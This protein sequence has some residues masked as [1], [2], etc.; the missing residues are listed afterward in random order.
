MNER[1]SELEKINYSEIK[2]LLNAIDHE[3]INTIL[4]NSPSW[5]DIQFWTL[6]VPSAEIYVVNKRLWDLSNTFSKSKI[7]KF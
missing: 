3:K 1:F 5:H 6:I 7:V 4:L 2:S